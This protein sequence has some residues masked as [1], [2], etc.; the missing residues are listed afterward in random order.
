MPD[1]RTR[2]NPKLLRDSLPNACRNY[3]ARGFRLV[4]IV[5]GYNPGI[6]QNMLDGEAL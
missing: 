1:F 2:E 3:L 4:V 5:S 6:Q